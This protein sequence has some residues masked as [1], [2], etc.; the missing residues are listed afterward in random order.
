MWS[1]FLKKNY[2]AKISG[3]V[4]CC[5]YVLKKFPVWVILMSD[6]LTLKEKREF[7]RAYKRGRAFV[8]PLLVTY[9]IKN[10]SNN[11]RYGITTGKKIG[12][13]VQRNRARRVIRAAFY[14]LE[15]DIKKGYD[16]VFVARGKTPYVKSTDVLSCMQSHFKSAGLIIKED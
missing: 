2:S 6:A 8:S 7:S 11:L 14:M 3:R 4:L 15:G 12:K 5:L 16:I 13:A 9:I 1:V 10:N